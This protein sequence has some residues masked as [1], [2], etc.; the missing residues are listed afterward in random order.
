MLGGRELLGACQALL[1]TGAL[2]DPYDSS[3]G[4]LFTILFLY[5]RPDMYVVF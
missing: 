3:L 1:V 2:S 5:Y 4:P